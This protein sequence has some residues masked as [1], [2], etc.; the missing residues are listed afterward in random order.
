MSPQSAMASAAASLL[1]KDVG[2]TLRWMKAFSAVKGQST[3]GSCAS[4][5]AVIDP[6]DPHKVHYKGRYT[7]FSLQHIWEKYDYLQTHLL[8]RECVLA[9]IGQNPRL[10][11]SELNA[12]VTPTLF[13]NGPEGTNQNALLTDGRADMTTKTP[14]AQIS[15]G[16]GSDKKAH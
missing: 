12:G 3:A 15:S 11:D 13:M 14:A 10:I 1:T 9:Q 6:V 5:T 4:G 7:N 2:R 8:L 16:K